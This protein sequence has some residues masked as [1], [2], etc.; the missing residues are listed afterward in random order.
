MDSTN[1]NFKNCNVFN[2]KS[3]YIIR[4]IFNHLKQKKLYSMVKHNKNI[5]NKLDV[6]LEDFLQIEI[7][8]I[9]KENMF[10]KFISKS[11]LLHIF[12]IISKEE[13]KE[14]I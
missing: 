8:L 6:N 13:L 11:T 14:I 5:K 3:K 9:P 7:E 2:I 1:K 4:K 10:G 12:F